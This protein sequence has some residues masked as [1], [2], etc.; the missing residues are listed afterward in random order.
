MKTTHSHT[1]IAWIQRNYAFWKCLVPCLSKP[2]L[3]TTSVQ[4]L[5]AA[6]VS[7]KSFILHHVPTYPFDDNPT[8]F[9][10]PCHLLALTGSNSC[11]STAFSSD[12]FPVIIDSSFTIAASGEID[13]FE[14]ASYTATQKVTLCGISAGL[15]VAGIGYV[16]W[17]F[18]DHL[19]NPIT[20]RLHAIDIPSL[21]I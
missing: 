7:N 8:S 12:D 10:L 14:P 11:S 3:F 20:M 15:A 2:S 16:Y 19:D 18:S 17:T 4:C 13:N 6:Y 5:M 9:S 21:H 1:I